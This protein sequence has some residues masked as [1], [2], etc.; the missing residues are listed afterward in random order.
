MVKAW[1]MRRIYFELIIAFADALSGDRAD[2]P[3][4]FPDQVKSSRLSRKDF[5][6]AYLRQ[7]ASR[8]RRQR[9][10]LADQLAGQG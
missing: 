8:P 5:G 4:S 2:L 10:A 7:N 1:L 6:A 9:F 3:T